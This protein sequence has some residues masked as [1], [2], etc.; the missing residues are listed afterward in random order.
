MFYARKSIEGF[1]LPLQ[2]NIWKLHKT[3]GNLSWDRT[4][5]N[6]A[7]HLTFLVSAQWTLLEPLVYFQCVL[8][9][10]GP[11]PFKNHWHSKLQAQLYHRLALKSEKITPPLTDHPSQNTISSIHPVKRSNN[12]SP[13][14]N[15][16]SLKVSQ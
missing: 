2:Q 9:E 7:V 3:Q 10:A 1:H 6:N 8:Q 5:Q 12:K 15:L 4:V 13:G 14:K 16:S 11:C